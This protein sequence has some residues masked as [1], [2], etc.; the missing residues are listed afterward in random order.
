MK[1]AIYTLSLAAICAWFGSGCPIVVTCEDVP[2]P[3]GEVCDLETGACEKIERD[4]RS[5]EDICRNGDVCDE[6][7]GQCRPE[8]LRCAEQFKSCPDGQA[9]NATSGFC[10]PAFRCETASDCGAAEQCNEA[11]QE[12]EPRVCEPGRDECPAAFVCGDA[13]RCIAGCRPGEGSCRSQEFCLALSGEL[14]GRCVPNCRSDSECPFGQVCDVAAAPNSRCVA[15][16]PCSV[17]ADCR[18]DEVCL[19]AVCMQPPCSSDD[20]CLATQIC[21][22]ATGTC[23]DATCEEDVYG[24]AEPANHARESAFGLATG[25]YTELV[26]CAGRSDWFAVDLRATDI[27]TFRLRQHLPEPDLD[28]YVY[29]RNGVLRAANEQ[30][31]QVSSLRLAAG[32]DQVLFVEVRGRGFATATYDLSVST[33]FC[34]NDGFEENDTRADATVIPSAVGVPSEVALTS[35]GF[36]EDWFR[37]EVADPSVGLRLDRTAGT[38]DLEIDLFTPDGERFA[39][40]RDAP[41][42]L[43]RTGATGSYYVRSA[44]SL[45]QAGNYRLTFEIVAPWFCDGVGDHGTRETA[46]S[47]S[48]DLVHQETFCPLDGSWEVDWLELSVEADGIIEARVQPISQTAP[49]EVAL[50]SWDGTTEQIVRTAAADGTARVLKA[51]VDPSLQYFLR[52]ISSQP[53]DRIVTEPR[54]EVSW[55]SAP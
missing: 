4:C 20:E 7:T 30:L 14:L 22:R 33:E 25:Q 47:L 21:E 24:L 28:L 46:R 35:C 41:L 54:Y 34:T 39:L 19:D 3:F 49:L 53:V 23:R 45:G 42:V 32:R 44:T 17:D 50:I 18:V 2:C 6:L 38:P 48:R 51:A 13:G 52:V 9:C 43:L 26:L 36:D 5:D 15:E 12:C 55:R 31:G 37:L 11:T 27:V 16:A 10:V 1:H 8:Q 29:D 40:T